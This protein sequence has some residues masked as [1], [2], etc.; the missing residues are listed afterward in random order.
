MH[1]A[2]D[3]MMDEYRSAYLNFLL[4]LIAFHFS[5]ALFGWLTFTWVVSSFTSS[6]VLGS[7]YLLMRYAM[8][9]H[10]RF[11]LPA[12]EVITGRFT[13]D[14]VLGA[15]IGSPGGRAPH[16]AADP[17][18]TVVSREQQALAAQSQE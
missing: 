7:L 4:G 15:L 10:S 17:A 11:R 9:V 18:Q 13:G 6:C 5:A 2:V 3:G 14:E 16:D 8:R 1:P 12:N